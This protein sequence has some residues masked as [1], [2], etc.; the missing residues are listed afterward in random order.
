MAE[1]VILLWGLAVAIPFVTVLYIELRFSRA[2]KNIVSL[3]ELIQADLANCRDREAVLAARVS[4][5]ERQ[6]GRP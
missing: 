2:D 1:Q 5:L 3:F 4:D 6:I